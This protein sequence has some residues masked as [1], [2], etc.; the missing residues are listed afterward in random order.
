MKE[1]K[2]GDELVDMMVGMALQT[3]KCQTVTKNSIFVHR[4]SEPHT[5]WA[6]G[7]NTQISEKCRL[8]LDRICGELR[9]RYDL[10]T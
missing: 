1:Q 5:N 9:L 8:E 7:T 6:Y 2:T 4:S 3:E 10:K